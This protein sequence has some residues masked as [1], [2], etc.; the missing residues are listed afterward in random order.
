MQNRSG[1]CKPYFVCTLLLLFLLQASVLL[2]YSQPVGGTAPK[3]D[4]VLKA[5]ITATSPIATAPFIALN[6][7][8][9]KIKLTL[10]EDTVLIAVASWC[11]AC[12]QWLTYL[13]Q[14]PKAIAGKHVVLIYGDEWLDLERSLKMELAPYIEKCILDEAVVD[15]GVNAYIA[16]KRKAVHS[17]L[18]QPEALRDVGSLPVLYALPR[19]EGLSAFEPA[20][21]PSVYN[22]KSRQFNQKMQDVFKLR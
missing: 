15:K 9:E 19:M 12:H 17:M 13:K 10:T 4:D 1:L 11:G 6:E 2:V 20:F 18:T 14:N 7:R 22:P 8:G 5:Q 21:F 3:K 16:Q